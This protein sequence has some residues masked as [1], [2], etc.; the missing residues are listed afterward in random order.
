MLHFG[1]GFGFF[2]EMVGYANNSAHEWWLVA[3][4]ST[5]STFCVPNVKRGNAGRSPSVDPLDWFTLLVLVQLD[6]DV[7]GIELEIFILGENRSFPS[8]CACTNQEIG[9]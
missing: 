1:S 2:C 8:Y 9:V 7:L 3:K 4:C 6:W 5:L